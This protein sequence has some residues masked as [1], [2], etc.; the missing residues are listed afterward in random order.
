MTTESKDEQ[1]YQYWI[2]DNHAVINGELFEIDDC[3]I[4]IYAEVETPYW[5]SSDDGWGCACTA[6]KEVT[7]CPDGSGDYVE[8]WRKVKWEEVNES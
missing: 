1:I 7:R 3:T 8:V 5:G 6:Y 4:D 2:P